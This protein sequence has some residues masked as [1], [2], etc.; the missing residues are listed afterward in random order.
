MRGRLGFLLRAIGFDVRCI[1]KGKLT[2]GDGVELALDRIV[3]DEFLV[4]V[5]ICQLHV[6][7]NGIGKAQLLIGLF[8]F[9]CLVDNELKILS[10][11]RVTIPKKSKPT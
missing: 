9:E 10:K 2:V 4:P 11:M 1:G 5:V 7:S 8:F 6:I 3:V